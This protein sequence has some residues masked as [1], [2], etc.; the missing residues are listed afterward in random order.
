[1]QLKRKADASN[2]VLYIMTHA[3]AAL[4][5]FVSPSS[6]AISTAIGLYILAGLGWSVGIHR[7]LIHRS[8]VTHRWVENTLAL[9]GALSGLGGP[10][11]TSRSHFVR[12]YCQ[13]N[14]GV[15]FSDQPNS[16]WQS[17]LR[18]PLFCR[19]WLEPSPPDPIT[20]QLKERVFFRLL[21][22]RLLLLGMSGCVLYAVGG[23]SFLVW[24]LFAR[25]AA[26]AGIFAIFDYVCHSPNWG[27]Q[28]FRI[29]GVPCEGRNNWII[30]MLT[31]GEGWHNNHHAMPSSP[32]MGIGRWDLDLGYAFI[33]LMQRFG[34]AWDVVKPKTAVS[35]NF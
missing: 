34:L 17:Y 7:G 21:E 15:L 23:A 8:F 6:Y 20:E 3:G 27:S 11:L 12:D 31:L 10:V 22:N 2:I 26:T 14:Q 32:R 4:C 13:S 18:S 35:A 28:R 33:W 5:F 29:D 19:S 16:F 9:L 1:M 30:G 24:G 25:L